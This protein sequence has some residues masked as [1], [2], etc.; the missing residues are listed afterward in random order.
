MSIEVKIP[1]NTNIVTINGLYQWDYGQ[2]LELKSAEI[3]SETIEI[4]F[5]SEG[6]SET[7]VLSCSFSEGVG[8]V[9]IPDQLLETPACITGWIYRFDNTGGYT[10]KVIKLPIVSRARP[11]SKE[12]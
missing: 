7:L 5:A 12:V 2:V 4:H 10:W 1:S 6:M 8:V 11:I 9:E 3:V